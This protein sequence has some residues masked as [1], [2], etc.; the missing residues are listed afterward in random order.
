MLCSHRSSAEYLHYSVA[1]ELLQHWKA[2]VVVLPALLRVGQMARVL[3]RVS[4]HW[5]ALRLFVP[6]SEHVDAS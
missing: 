5:K 1:E 3:Q 6:G 4:K 2:E